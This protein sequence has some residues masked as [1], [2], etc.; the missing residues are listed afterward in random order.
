[1][2]EALARELCCT[3]ND[4]AVI[5]S[6]AGVRHVA[7]ESS[8]TGFLHKR[9]FVAI[10]DATNWEVHMGRQSCCVLFCLCDGSV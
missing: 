9:L 5:V 3:L 6:S 7:I 8:G 10:H 1:M 4:C 2:P